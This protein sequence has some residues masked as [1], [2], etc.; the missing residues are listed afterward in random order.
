M[1]VAKTCLPISPKSAARVS[2]RCRKTR[3]SASKSSKDRRASRRRISS[4]YDRDGRFARSGGR[5][6]GFRTAGG[7]QGEKGNAFTFMAR[8]ANFVIRG[9]GLRGQGNRI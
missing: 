8:N 5:A 7:K 4:R 9:R 1:M 3:R 2:S 6:G